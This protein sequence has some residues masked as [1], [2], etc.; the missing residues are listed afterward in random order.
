MSISVA[1]SGMSWLVLDKAQGRTAS[2]QGRSKQHHRV[3]CSKLDW[4]AL[5]YV[6]LVIAVEAE[7]K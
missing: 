7:I 2:W 3:K 1:I 5:D 4:E 6:E